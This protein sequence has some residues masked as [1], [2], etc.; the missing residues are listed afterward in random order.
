MQRRGN[1]GTSS[2]FFARLF[3]GA[4]MEMRDM[5]I[6]HVLQSDHERWRREFDDLYTPVHDGL[7]SARKHRER[8]VELLTTHRAKIES[9]E[10]VSYQPNAVNIYESISEPLGDAF[11]TFLSAAARSTKL[12]QKVTKF[13]GLDLSMLYAKLPNFQAGIQ[14]LRN[15]KDEALADYL[16]ATRAGWSENLFERRNDLEHGPWR[17]DDVLVRP[18]PNGAPTMVE[19]QVNNEP[20]SEWVS[21]MLA[22][23]LAFVEETTALAVQRALRPAHVALIEVTAAEVDPNFA[24]RFQD[25]WPSSDS[26]WQ[27]RYSPEGFPNNYRP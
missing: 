13:L 8:I 11:A 4:G 21:R 14:K 6:N 15:D 26:G 22:Q 1:E 7:V 5:V 2:P 24:R 18:G 19:P 3:V 9:G 25:V 16:E 10:I 20:V 23:V 12:H 27:L 17:L